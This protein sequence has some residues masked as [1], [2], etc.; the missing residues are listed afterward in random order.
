MWGQ[1]MAIIRNLFLYVALVVGLLVA[2]STV[3]TA[4]APLLYL[5][6]VGLLLYLPIYAVWQ[7]LKAFYRMLSGKDQLARAGNSPGSMPEQ[8]G[9][10]ASVKPA[11]EIARQKLASAWLAVES[12]LTSLSLK[13][14]KRVSGRTGTLSRMF[15]DGALES[16]SDKLDFL[17]R[18]LQDE[19]LERIRFQYGALSKKI[20]GIEQELADIAASIAM[21]DE[22]SGGKYHRLQAT[23]LAELGREK[24]QKADLVRR[25]AVYFDAYGVKLAPSQAEVLLSRVDASDVI[26]MTTVFSVI[27]SMTRQFEKANVQSGENVE[28]A[29]K[30]YGMYIVLLELQMHIQ[31]QYLSRLTNNYVPGI[32]LIMEEAKGLRKD[33]VGEIKVSKETK[34]RR[35]YEQNLRSQD[36]TIEVTGFYREVLQKD[37]AKVSRAKVLL[38]K[39][40][41]VAKNTLR[42]VQVSSD[43]SALISK[44]EA[45]YQEVM[46]LQ[47]P[48]LVPFENLQVQAK[49]EAVTERLKAAQRD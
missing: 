48:E 4:I 43:L 19:E 6:V 42:T 18:Q 26:Q 22:Q 15:R 16:D 23:R 49:F 33:T 29:K 24:G 45:L 37:A 21:H 46:A 47:V 3:L 35:V 11:A 27:S 14:Q 39:H 12:E 13:V 31:D 8:E 34:Y 36:L 2:A 41:G 1:N 10:S 28:V 17:S 9:S 40:Y 25:A 30:Y 38:K 7:A 32:E 5:V 20:C 44:N